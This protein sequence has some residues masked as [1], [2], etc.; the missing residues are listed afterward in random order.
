MFID[1]PQKWQLTTR[2]PRETSA[3]IYKPSHFQDN[4]FKL[5]KMIIENLVGNRGT[6]F[7]YK[8]ELQ[9]FRLFFHK[10]KK[11]KSDVHALQLGQLQHI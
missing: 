9:R 10:N 5:I 4:M 2:G 1:V 7:T 11:T 3:M 8:R 6:T